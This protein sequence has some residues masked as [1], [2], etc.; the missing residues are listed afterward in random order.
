MDKASGSAAQYP[1]DGL[2][3]IFAKLDKTGVCDGAAVDLYSAGMADFY[4]VLMTDYVVDIPLFERLIPQP[5]SKVLDLACGAGRIAIAL[6]KRGYR[7]DGL[8]LSRAMLDLAESNLAAEGAEIAARVRYVEGDMT[9]FELPDRYE[10]IILGI[11]SISLLLEE[12]QRHGLFDC[13]RRHLAPDGAFI[14]DVLDLEDEKWKKFDDYHDVWSRE[15]DEGTD[16]G[17]IGQRFYPEER[18]FIFN[19][20][21]ET[22]GW[23]GDTR[24]LLGRSEK[25][26]L[27]RDQLVAELERAGLT[28]ADEFVAESQ[29]YFAVRQKENS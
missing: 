26:W 27:G 24:R 16:V 15:S 20:Y 12:D 14:F 7:V 11:T 13:V 23:D 1:Q 8:E 4:N 18:R 6:A 5:S 3:G 21:R 28:L 22:I 2:H 25:A 29:R 10:L 19:V 9:A 17:I